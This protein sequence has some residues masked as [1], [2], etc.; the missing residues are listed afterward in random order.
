MKKLM[1]ALAMVMLLCGTA[2][3]E[4]CFNAKGSAIVPG[5]YARY[6]GS[7][8]YQSDH[9]IIS[10]I[11]NTAVT[12]RVTVYDQDGNDVSSYCKLYTGGDNQTLEELSSGVNTFEI[13]AN[14]TRLFQFYQSGMTKCMIGY[15]VI[16]WTSSD[17]KQRKSLVA[18]LRSNGKWGS[19]TFYATQL[20][21]NNGQPF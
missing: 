3:A 6:S 17:A 4:D 1:F 21:I 20:L 14:S 10:N 18:S 16:E 15:A 11:D 13:P 8:I 7:N 12:C 9:V 19:G 2:F 5:M